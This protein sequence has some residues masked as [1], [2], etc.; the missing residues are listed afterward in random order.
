M[1]F[2][3]GRLETA[4]ENVDPDLFWAPRGGGGGT[5]AIVTSVTLR[6]F[7]DPTAV[8]VDVSV[9]FPRLGP[10]YWAAVHELIDLL[11]A[12]DDAGGSGFFYLFPNL[13]VPKAGA[14]FV[15]GMFFANEMDV[16]AIQRLW[17]PFE[18]KVEALAGSNVSV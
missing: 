2:P 3:Q 12:I 9:R 1:L 14:N 6:T 13:G 18:T 15:A 10:G 8:K 4:N 7:P 16:G 11:P 5:Y 17:A